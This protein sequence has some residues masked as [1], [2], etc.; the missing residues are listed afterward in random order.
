MEQKK[1]LIKKISAFTEAEAQQLFDVVAAIQG[2][3]KE[4]LTAP[5]AEK[6]TIGA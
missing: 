6:Q 2:A 5:Q 1:Q 4:N 3:K